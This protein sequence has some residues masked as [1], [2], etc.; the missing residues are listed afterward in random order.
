[1]ESESRADQREGGTDV[2]RPRR[3]RGPLRV[4]GSATAVCSLALGFL[5]TS[6]ASVPWNEFPVDRHEALGQSSVS[7]GGSGT[8]ALVGGPTSI[9]Q[10]IEVLERAEQAALDSG[11]PLTPEIEQAAA[12]LGALL[13]TYLAQQRADADPRPGVASSAQPVATADAIPV[14]DASPVSNVVVPADEKPSGATDADAVAA[15]AVDADAAAAEAA[16]PEAAH[17]DGQDVHA[18][19]YEP[20]TFEDVVVAATRLARLLDPESA[21]Y[22][23]GIVLDDGTRVGP[24]VVPA[25]LTSSLLDVVERY[26]DTTAAYANGRIPTAVLCPL[27]FAPGHMLRCDA[28]KQLSDLSD[29]YEARFG[30]PIPIT[31]S[32]R[33]YAAQ[34]AVRIAKPH[35][36]AV[37]G[38]SN[39]G[40][41]L[42]VDLSSPISS[43]TTAQYVWLRLHG[44]DYGWDNPSWARLDGSKPEPWHFEFFAAGPTPDRAVSPE[45]VAKWTTP[46]DDDQ[47]PVVKPA[48][49]TDKPADGKRD[50]PKH[51]GKAEPRDDVKRPPAGKPGGKPPTS[52][53]PT[54]PKAE[55]TD[56]PTGQPTTPPSGE[57]TKPPTGE[58][59][60]PPTGEP[61]DPP[62]GEPTDPPTGEEPGECPDEPG[63]G[64]AEGSTDG[65]AEGNTDGSSDGS[66]DDPDAEDPDDPCPDD[67]TEP[68]D[69]STDTPAPGPAQST[70]PSSSTS[71][72]RRPVG[73][74]SPDDA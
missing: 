7:V 4:L 52:G 46:P 20:V 43:G 14:S 56:P 60:D 27:D 36:A 51:D 45:D 19:G 49:K 74:P 18:H 53:K 67:P 40:W 35:L 12:E 68:T 47:K 61:T 73:D 33:S 5:A 69:P 32:Y 55:P 65:S 62:T 2:R 9:A 23:S 34:V 57:P 16:A 1:M 66:T 70:A 28:A 3:W 8:T 24:R 41:G 29:A 37:P 54:P 71:G 58:P 50:R 39:H 30:V 21:G 72:R 64:G 13:S 31:D 38:T 22:S 10:V 48:T 26:A 17:P 25:G 6:V 63:D 59:T 42:A 44:P 15:D 11:R